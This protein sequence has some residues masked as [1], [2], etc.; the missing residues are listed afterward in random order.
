MTWNIRPTSVNFC[1]TLRVSSDSFWS[2]PVEMRLYGSVDAI[3]C[4]TASDVTEWTRQTGHWQPIRFS[5]VAT[6]A[7]FTD[8]SMRRHVIR[9]TETIHHC[10]HDSLQQAERGSLPRCEVVSQLPAEIEL[11]LRDE[12]IVPVLLRQIEILTATIDFA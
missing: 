6:V 4:A 5:H 7:L 1:E 11:R 3:S 10:M 9:R 8:R 12:C 2:H